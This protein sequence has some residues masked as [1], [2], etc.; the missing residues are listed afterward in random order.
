MPKFNELNI[1]PAQREIRQIFLNRIIQ[2]KGL[3]KAAELISGILMP[4]PA[5][6]MAAMQLLAEEP[7]LNPVLANW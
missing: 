1:E 3:S 5:A 7:R 2:A 4:T 6:M